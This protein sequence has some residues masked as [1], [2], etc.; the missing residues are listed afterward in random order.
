[1]RPR[2]QDV[3]QF[4]GGNLRGA[5]LGDHDAGRRIG[6]PRRVGNAGIANQR[7]DKARHHGIARAGYVHDAAC[8]G[9]ERRGFAVARHR[10]EAAL[11]P[12]HQHALAADLRDQRGGGSLHG[13]RAS[14]SIGWPSACASS[15]DIGRHYTG[16]AVSGIVRTLG[17]DDD[18]L[19]GL[20]RRRDDFRHDARRQ[21]AL[22]V[23]GQHDRIDAAKAVAH[24][25]HDGGFDAGIHR[26]GFLA[27]GTQQV[28][29]VQVGH[30]AC[31]DGRHA[32]RC[33][34][35]RRHDPRAPARW[36]AI[37]ALPRRARPPPRSRRLAPSPAILRATLPAPPSGFLR[38]RRIDHQGGCF[39]RYP[40]HRAIDIAVEHDV[41]DHQEALAAKLIED[42]LEGGH[43]VPGVD[44]LTP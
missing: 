4:R 3:P 19:A 1:M 24:C 14:L 32:P 18:R 40:R 43:G 36:L 33:L 22:A 27:I 13:P 31:L 44:F 34:D 12:R 16:A 17:I 6:E 20:P 42:G 2:Q 9:V 25:P 26:R 28:R 35:E 38:R 10:D 11:A 41:A 39:G 15:A 7:E 23:V 8:R 5:L 30:E 21:H 29:V 37:A